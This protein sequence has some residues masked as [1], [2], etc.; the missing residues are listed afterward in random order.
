MSIF[1]SWLPAEH[2]KIVLSGSKDTWIGSWTKVSFK[3]RNVQ[4]A[5]PFSLNRVSA[6]KKPLPEIVFSSQRAQALLERCA[7]CERRSSL[8]VCLPVSVCMLQ[9]WLIDRTNTQSVGAD[10]RGQRGGARTQLRPFGKRGHA[11]PI[12]SSHSVDA[13]RLP[14]AYSS[15]F[16][17][18]SWT[19]LPS[20]QQSVFTLIWELM[21]LSEIIVKANCRFAGFFLLQKPTQ[22]TLQKWIE[23]HTCYFDPAANSWSV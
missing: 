17:V 6:R 16:A 20:G 8:S 7:E 2:P 10:G 23:K 15:P 1:Q 5:Y 22:R 14:A 12:E 4:L 19:V 11:R 3:K 21:L 9:I 13:P 18:F